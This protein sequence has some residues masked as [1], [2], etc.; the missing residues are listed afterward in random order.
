MANSCAYSFQ[1]SKVSVKTVKVSIN[2]FKIHSFTTFQKWVDKVFLTKWVPKKMLWGLRQD[3]EFSGVPRVAVVVHEIGGEFS[4][5]H[6]HC[7]MFAPGC[8]EKLYGY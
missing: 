5:G 6:V 4:G 3:P 1:I 7:Y 8:K 2:N